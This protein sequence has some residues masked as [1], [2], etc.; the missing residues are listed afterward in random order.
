[1]YEREDMDDELPDHFGEFQL[2]KRKKVER[3]P[4][5]KDLVMLAAIEKDKNEVVDWSQPPDVEVLDKPSI[6]EPI[7]SY[8]PRLKVLSKE[9]ALTGVQ[10]ISELRQYPSKNKRRRRGRDRGTTAESSVIGDE[11]LLEGEGEEEEEDEAESFYK[12]MTPIEDLKLRRS[13]NE[14]KEERKERKKRLK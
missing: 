5:E 2:M 3:I 11:S 4:V 9:E 12:N 6:K 8:I 7:L 10:V 14:T 13:K 1:M